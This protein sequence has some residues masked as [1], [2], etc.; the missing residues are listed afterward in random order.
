MF[1][2]KLLFW[3]SKI[4]VQ[5]QAFD[6]LTESLTSGVGRFCHMFKLQG[7]DIESWRWI[8]MYELPAIYQDVLSRDILST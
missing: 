2:H 5:A 8:Y 6:S 4:Y 7:S 3:G 1:K